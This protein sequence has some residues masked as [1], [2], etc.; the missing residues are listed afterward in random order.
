MWKLEKFSKT[1]KPYQIYV[2]LEKR[3]LNIV[4]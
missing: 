3:V 4:S 1:A 2:I